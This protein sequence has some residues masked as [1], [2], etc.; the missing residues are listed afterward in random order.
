MCAFFVKAV[1]LSFSVQQM[2]TLAFL[3]LLHGVWV[4]A[5]MAAYDQGVKPVSF[6]CGRIS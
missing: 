6:I 2:K 4:E 3:P 5:L 1:F